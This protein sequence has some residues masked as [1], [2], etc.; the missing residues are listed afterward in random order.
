MLSVRRLEI[1][2]RDHIASVGTGEVLWGSAT[3]PGLSEREKVRSE[4]YRRSLVLIPCVRA[5]NLSKY[6]VEHLLIR[7]L[8]RS[9]YGDDDSACQA[10]VIIPT[11][12]A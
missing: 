6:R 3:I 5:Y 7:Y 8:A 12:V 1:S 2:C 10:L 9:M 4:A 11:P